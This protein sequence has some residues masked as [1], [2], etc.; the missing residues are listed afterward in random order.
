MKRYEADQFVPR[1][2]A[3]C[4]AVI[5]DP[6]NLPKWFKGAHSVTTSGGYPKV[7]GTIAWRMGRNYRFE[8]RVVTNDLPERFVLAVKTSSGDSTVTNRFVAESSGTRYTKTVEVTPRGLLGL[9]VPLFLPGAVRNEVKRAAALA[10]T[11]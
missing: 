8:A 11:A 4:A 3:H 2:P 10:A 9:L 6:E 5:T 1:P 7:G